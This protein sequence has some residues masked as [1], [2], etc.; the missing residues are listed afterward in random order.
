M[1][2][3]I[4][5]KKRRPSFTTH[6]VLGL[7]LGLLWGLFFGEHGSW[8]KWIGD[9]YVGLLQ[10]AVLP[11]VA[12]SLI[13]NIGRLS[14]ADGQRLLRVGVGVMLSLWL[15]GLVTLV[16][17]IGAFPDW[18]TGSFFSSRFTEDPPT[19][20]WL[21]LFVP[22][23]PF[24]ALAEN[25]I[26]AVVVFS[27][28]LGIALM[29]VPN[30]EAM[31]SPLSVAADALAKLNKL[32]VKLTPLGMFGIVAYTAGT[33]DLDQFRLIQGYLLTYG[34][35]ALILA[36][37]LLP[38]LIAAFTPFTF[39]E[40]AQASQGPLIAAFVIG[41]TFVVLPMVIN[42]VNKLFRDKDLIDEQIDDADYLVP[43][44]YPFPDIGRIV[45]LIF[46]PFAAWFYGTTI[47]LDRYP[48]LLG[49]GL[50]GSFGKPVITMP[51]LLN[52]A[53]LPSD[54]F[55]LFLASGVIA[56]RFGDL[57]KTMHLVTFTVLTTCFLNGLIKINWRKF[58]VAGAASVL[59][60][61]IAVLSI[62]TYLDMNFKDHY[63]KEHLITERER[64]FPRMRP[65]APL[66]DDMT[67]LILDSD[68]SSPN[69]QPIAENQTRVQ[70]IKNRGF[71]R[72]GFDSGNMPFAYESDSGQLI[73]F[74]IEMA[75][76][77][78]DDLGVNIEFVPLVRDNLYQD[79]KDDHF[80]VAMSA[81]EGTVH[82]ASELPAIE[83]YMNITLAIV[84]PDHEKRNFRSREDILAIEDLK[85][86]VVK[87]SFFAERA[88]KVL[89]EGVQI[90]ELQS[91]SEFF[92]SGPPKA[93]G[94]VISAESGSAWTLR[95]PKFTVANPLGGSIQVPLY[96][97]TDTDLEFETFLQNWLT[98]KRSDGTYD[99]L[100]DHWILGEDKQVEKPRW[101][102]VR[103]V[104][105]WVD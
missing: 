5:D 48:G 60:F 80:D 103:D 34:A 3:S 40:V 55:N 24:R 58:F 72:V 81:I 20:N 29:T 14:L 86:A 90:V 17:M 36:F 69:P 79:L 70:R 56:A 76:Y 31:L 93:N 4:V 7:L 42:A 27:I 87:G 32:V 84:V 68:S 50:L 94:L 45:G 77:L 57:M 9:V 22:A 16:I 89:P 63:S 28:G 100:Y 13:V 59:L 78:A 15:I 104:L 98:L 30:K 12:V 91:A 54:I 35:S 105:G 85:L 2:E 8:V 75:Y 67:P 37:F 33:I 41:N 95:Q 61:S 47:D 1:V 99:E 52:I 73:G 96:Y 21:D 43:L 65:D 92:E 64:V 11:Y 49:V 39:R 102:I 66:A 101:C 18:Q 88:P 19:P 97:L 6:I 53:E 46:I 44:A 25:S 23:N 51:L 83:P 10:M 82:Q 71:I 38:A 62:R 74:D 26:P